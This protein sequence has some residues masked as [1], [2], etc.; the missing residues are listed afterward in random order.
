MSVFEAW[1]GNCH[2]IGTDN[3]K[4]SLKCYAAV[5]AQNRNGFEDT[6]REHFAAQSQK[7]LWVEEVFP[8]IQWLKRHGHH[9]TVMAL[10]KAVHEHHR[11]ELGA[12]TKAGSEP[13]P[14]AP[15]EY[16]T[17][18]QHDI[19]PLPEQIGIPFWDKE[20]ITPEL[21][22]L[23][24]GRPENS[25]GTLRT[26]FIVDA[27]LQK[28]VTGLFDPDGL[29]VPIRCLFKGEA[30]EE[31]K[32]VAPFLIDMTLPDGAWDNKD[33]VPDFHK[34]F[35]DKHWSHNTGIF[36]RTPA[37]MDVVWNHFRKFTRV[38]EE[39]GEI[40]F[41]RFWVPTTF[42]PMGKYLKTSERYAHVFFPSMI[43]EI[44]FNHPDN[45]RLVRYVPIEPRFEHRKL[46]IED[47]LGEIL[48]SYVEYIHI[49]RLMN[50]IDKMLREKEPELLDKIEA[51]PKSKRFRAARDLY[52]L[53][54]IDIKQA[55]AIMSI[56][57]RTGMNMLTEEAFDYITE[58]PFLLPY[59]KAQQLILSFAMITNM[60]GDT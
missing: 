32:S 27:K 47:A 7:L 17:I 49:V 37:S 33:I 8:I 38:P 42:Y 40:V 36:I 54:I 23:L 50:N 18:T 2:I 1:I 58:N 25:H 35:F 48:G 3:N 55:S 59:S 10:A 15:P 44:S 53:D 21:K 24:F 45:N 46:V 56:I 31:L 39:S 30:A 4:H 11:V 5:W 28:N 14:I 26:Y 57:Y 9:A 16:L 60:T 22:E 6:L 52:E 13:E 34:K 43:T 41:F 20:W 12:F 29:D 19:P 51:M